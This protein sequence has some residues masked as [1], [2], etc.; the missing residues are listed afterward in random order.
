MDLQGLL[1]PTPGSIHHHP[2]PMSESSAQTVSE[3]WPSRPC[4][5]P[6]T[7]RS[8]STSLWCRPSPSP[9]AAPPLAQLHAVPSGTGTVTRQQSSAL[10]FH[11]LRGAVGCHEGSPKL[12]CS[13]LSKPK[14]I[15]YLSYSFPSRPFTIFGCQGTLLT[16]IQLAISHN[17]Q[18]PF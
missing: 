6:C 7:A 3:L 10:P 15:N 13:G 16:R 4:P 5:P 18:N 17:P 1:N 14:D 2:N 12:S 9:P 11:S 8:M